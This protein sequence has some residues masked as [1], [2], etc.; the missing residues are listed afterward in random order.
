MAKL[1]TIV[2]ASDFSEGAELAVERAVRL[3]Q[4]HSAELWLLHAFDD[5]A[6]ASLRNFYD[7][8]RWTGA[9]PVLTARERLAQ[10]AADLSARFGVTVKAETRSGRAPQAIAAFARECGAGL[11]VMGVRG[12]DW[13]RYAL[14]GGSALRVVE[15]ADVPVLLVRRPVAADFA[16]VLV[17]TDFSE[18][19]RR[20]AQNALV[21]CPGVRPTLLHAYVVG[22]EGRMRLAGATN[23]DIER[24]REQEC[25]RAA[26]RMEAFLAGLA[27]D[28]GRFE[29]CLAHGYPA[30]AILKQ[31]VD[32]GAD[33][34]AVGKHGGSVLEERLL[35]SVAQNILYNASC[36]VLLSP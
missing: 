32:A 13:L 25:R 1:Q 26:E 3:A 9:D 19:A 24:Y 8:D 7:L 36:D 4:T 17:A 16:R 2:A 11:L 18:N 31:A 23:E 5:G 14:L 33:L 29:R 35:G 12:E 10:Q 15:H 28:G 20:A 34:I 21:L 22:F 6:W 27:E 30:A